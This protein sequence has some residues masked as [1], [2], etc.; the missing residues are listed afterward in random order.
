MYT[1]IQKFGVSKFFLKKLSVLFS[2][3]AINESKVTVKTF[4]R[5]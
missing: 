2:K 3:D 5:T 4:I 1:T